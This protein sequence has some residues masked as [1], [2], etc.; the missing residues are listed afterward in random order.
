[1]IKIQYYED[2]GDCECCGTYDEHSIVVTKDGEEV[3]EFFFCNHQGPGIDQEIDG[4]GSP[5]YV[6]DWL[7]GY[8]RALRDLG[9]T[10]E[11][12]DDS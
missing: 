5:L 9:Y 7:Q 2:S 11:V 1:M 4:W 3:Q 8:V 6:S 12:E 10:V